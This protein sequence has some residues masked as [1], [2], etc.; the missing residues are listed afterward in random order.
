[1][2][3]ENEAEPFLGESEDSAREKF[4]KWS[5]GGISNI[6]SSI[7]RN[8]SA[9][10]SHILVF[11]V[12]SLLW[13][14]FFLATERLLQIH[15]DNLKNSNGLTSDATYVKCGH[16][17]EEAK[18][19]G[20]QYDILSNHWV[21]RQCMDQDAVEEYQSD[22]SWFGYADEKR[23]ELLSIDAMS[24]LPYYYTNERDHIVHC[25]MLWRKQFRAWSEGRSYYDSILASGEH[26]IHCS[27]YLMNMT[28]WGTDFRSM[29]IK[30]WVG[31]AG[32]YVKNEI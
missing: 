17:T 21:P 2:S 7:K 29:P 19:L 28:D 22:G 16:S 27:E 23:T 13:G 26:T 24:E 30:V 8:C 1:M 18:A 14:L 12:T 6:S 32:C 15:Q 31:Y 25:A 9:F 20:C 4:P 10:S 3:L 11:I 5:R